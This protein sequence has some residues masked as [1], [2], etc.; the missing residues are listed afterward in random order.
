MP[1]WI[2][3]GISEELPTL[4]EQGEGSHLEYKSEYPEN[5]HELSR[6]IAAFASSGGGKILVGISDEGELIGLSGFEKS[7]NRDEILRRV[8]GLCAN[9]I[10]PAIRVDVKF[11]KERNSIVLAI[12]VPSGPQPI[13]YSGGKPYIRHL[14]S[15]RPAEPN[16]VSEKISSSISAS[17]SELSTSRPKSE[18]LFTVATHIIEIMILSDQ[19]HDRQINPWLD[20]MNATAEEI[21]REFRAIVVRNTIVDAGLDNPLR[22]ISSCLDR[23]ISHCHT[24]DSESW[25][26]YVGYWQTTC[27]SAREV[28][29]QHIG[30]TLLLD[31]QQERTRNQIFEKVR[32]LVDLDHRAESMV[33][34]SRVQ[35]LK[36]DAGMIG[37]ELLRLSYW[38]IDNDA[39]SFIENLRQ[40][41]KKIDLLETTIIR[42]DGGRSTQNLLSELHDCTE[43]I[44]SLVSSYIETP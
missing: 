24:L 22:E 44:Q 31:H 40:C 30:P 7:T 12:I 25:Q 43:Q 28:M 29:Q 41:A 21:A 14:S 16:E 20:R 26:E 13:Y 5:G 9:N 11:A 38:Y 42:L 37:R 3:K 34:D 6:E 18:V 36:D 17:S 10:S 4:R 19:V 39:D 35:E 8:Q 27:T 15:S 32:Q 1:V 2:D 23:A 33:E